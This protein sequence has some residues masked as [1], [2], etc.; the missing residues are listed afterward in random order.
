MLIKKTNNSIKNGVEEWSEFSKEETQILK[1]HLK[2]RPA[3]LRSWNGKQN[4]STISTFTSHN[5]QEQ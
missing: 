2:E 1:K 4:F 5:G 3:F